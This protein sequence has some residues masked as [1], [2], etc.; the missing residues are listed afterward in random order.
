MGQKTAV[1]KTG[2]TFAVLRTELK[3]PVMKKRLNKSGNCFEISFFRRCN[4]L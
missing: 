3:I 1:L 2:T 4:I